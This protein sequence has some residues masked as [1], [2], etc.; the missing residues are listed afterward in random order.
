[1]IVHRTVTFLL[2]IAAIPIAVGAVLVCAW[3]DMRRRQTI[4]YEFGGDEAAY[5]RAMWKDGL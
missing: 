2:V 1:M 4:L 5:A 3:V